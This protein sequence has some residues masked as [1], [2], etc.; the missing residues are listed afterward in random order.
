MRKGLIMLAAI[1]LT[2]TGCAT[3]TSA[4]LISADVSPEMVGTPGPSTEPELDEEAEM[5]TGS[6]PVSELEQIVQK[7]EKTVL[8]IRVGELTLTAVLEEN[9]S[10]A[11]LADMLSDGEIAIEVHNYGGFEK[12]GELPESLPRDDIQ[13]TAQ[14]G[15][16]MLYQ[17]NSIVFFHGSNS[18][19][20]TKLG[21]IADADSE[22]L[23]EAF[24]GEETQITLSIGE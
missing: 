13:T 14:P 16:I 6:E 17:G 22:L 19:A 5:K 4:P 18:W 2:L 10:A 23:R 20:Y 12:V 1:A 8:Y 3:S 21:T 15:D 24:G 7:E 11:A 9:R